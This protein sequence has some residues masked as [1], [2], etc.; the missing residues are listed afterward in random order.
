MKKISYSR[1]LKQFKILSRRVQ[2]LLKKTDEDSVFQLQK[3]KNKLNSLLLELKFAYS[4][5]ELKRILGAAV[6]VFGLSF[7]NQAKAQYFDTPVENPFGLVST[8]VLAAGTFADLDDDGDFDL[9]VGESY[10]AMQYFENTGTATNPAFADPILNPFGIDSIDYYAFPSF[11]DIDNDGDLDLFTGSSYWDYINYEYANSLHFFEN[12]GTASEPEF[13]SQVENPYGLDS[14]ERLPFAS[15]VDLDN[16]GDFDILV[17]ASQYNYYGPDDYLGVLQYFE[18]TGS[19]TEP[20]FEAPLEN[21]FGLTST[22]LLA[23]PTFAD[24]DGDSDFDLLVGEYY[25][26]MHYFENTGTATSPQ[27]A[28]PLVNPFGLD[29]V[30]Q[31]ALPLFIDLD[32]DGDFDLLVGEG[33]D[34]YSYDYGAP[35]QYFENI[36]TVGIVS[37]DKKTDFN[38]YPNPVR[39][40]L[41]IDTELA[42]D[43]IEIIDVLG[44]TSM[45]LINPSN[46][47]SVGDLKS[48]LYTVKV[49][50]HDGDYATK[51]ILKE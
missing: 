48:G 23:T 5:L 50:F 34:Y 17:G 35:M 25:G 32:D 26:A 37:L 44:K 51:K 27:F 49:F 8:N 20:A 39:D 15:F 18:N 24:L 2:F 1:K 6:L 33:Y 43:R 19:A 31:V 9:L 21:P 30:I 3:L 29:S 13:A 7:S 45:R 22:L 12:I 28:T 47:F 11:V 42:I 46:R 4:R 36:N 10:G 38:L 41:T 40:L 16:D 14:L